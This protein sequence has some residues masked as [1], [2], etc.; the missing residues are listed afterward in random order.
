MT[1]YTSGHEAEQ[2]A[3]VYLKKLGYKIVD[4]NWKTKY[5]EIDIIAE[6]KRRIYFIEVKSRK[7]SSYGSGLDYITNKKL[8][9]MTFAAE[10][11]VSNKGWKGDFQLAAIGITNNEYEFVAID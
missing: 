7:S 3:V 4:I 9:Q 10:M 11:W 6:N 1:N 5:C 8:R 2:D